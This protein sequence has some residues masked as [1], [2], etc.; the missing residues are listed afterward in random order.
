MQ[1]GS[2]QASAPVVDGGN[3]RKGGRNASAHVI[4]R[5]QGAQA[6]DRAEDG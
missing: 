5:F 2:G 4:A 1:V 6:A 3:Y